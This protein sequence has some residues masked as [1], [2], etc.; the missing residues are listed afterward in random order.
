[1]RQQSG[2]DADTFLGVYVEDVFENDL[3]KGGSSHSPPVHRETL[4]SE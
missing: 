2:G 4:H 1:M 3:G